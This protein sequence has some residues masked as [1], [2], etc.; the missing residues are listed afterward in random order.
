LPEISEVSGAILDSADSTEDFPQGYKVQLSDDGKNWGKE[1]ATGNGTC[2]YTQIIFPVEQT[3][4]IR[5]NQT[6]SHPSRFWSIAE[7]QVLQPAGAHRLQIAMAD[8]SKN[9]ASTDPFNIDPLAIAPPQKNETK[10]IEP[11]AAAA[12]PSTKPQPPSLPKPAL[13]PPPPSKPPA[14]ASSDETLEILQPPPLPP[15]PPGF[16]PGAAQATST[17]QRKP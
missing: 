5:I 7:L 13:T 17:A 12:S 6:G 4:F 2:A 3:K 10:G 9:A 1:V 8:K 15:L 11:A 16:T 14:P